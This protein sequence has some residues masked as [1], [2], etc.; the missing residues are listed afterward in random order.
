[1]PKRLQ[2]AGI[3]YQKGGEKNS[4][5]KVRRKGRKI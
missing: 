2:E 1:M 4:T 5:T 3:K